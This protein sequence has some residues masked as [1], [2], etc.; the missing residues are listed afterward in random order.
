[1]LSYSDPMHP[2]AVTN[3][4]ATGKNYSYDSNGNMTARGSQTLSWNIDN[5]V[6]SVSISG[7][8]TTSMDFDYTGVRVKKDGPGGPTLFPFTGIEIEPNG[9]FTKFIR[10][11]NETLASK[12]LTS[13]GV[14]SQLFYHND[15]LGGTNVITD[16][17]GARCQ[18]NEY[19]P[20][21]GVSRSD[22]AS[23]P[24]DPTH[25]FTGQEL[26]PET[27]FYYY[28]GRYYDQEIGR[29][30][31]PDLFVQWPDDS[32][33]LNRYSYVLN[34]SQGYIEIRAVTITKIRAAVT[35]MFRFIAG[36]DSLQIFLAAAKNQ[37][38]CCPGIKRLLLLLIIVK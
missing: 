21:G 5:R 15:H 32:Q 27:G 37:N 17:T 18:L 9:T 25:R 26:D 14:T 4:S 3:N 30:V 6:T 28:V 23:P 10:M 12:K 34:N 33:N 11:G 16:I 29:F 2:S 13:A 22:V 1:V 38:I 20:W 19:A 36:T 24:C 7:G 31:S 8:G 35:A